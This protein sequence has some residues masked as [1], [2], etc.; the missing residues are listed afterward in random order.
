M[1]IKSIKFESEISIYLHDHSD[2][3]VTKFVTIKSSDSVSNPKIGYKALHDHHHAQV[4]S[5]HNAGE[6]DGYP[7]AGPHEMIPGQTAHYCADLIMTV[8]FA[9]GNEEELWLYT[10]EEPD[11]EKEDIKRAYKLLLEFNNQTD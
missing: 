8:K 11:I 4:T 7:F 5:L 2:V 6:Y 1:N 9:D 10:P 3:G